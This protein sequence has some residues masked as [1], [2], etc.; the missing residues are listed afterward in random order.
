VVNPFFTP[1]VVVTQI[2]VQFT[3]M[4]GITM[5]QVTFPAPLPIQ[6]FGSTLGTPRGDMRF[7]LTLNVGCSI[8]HNGNMAVTVETRDGHGRRNS[9]RVDIN[10]R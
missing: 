6:E 9:K 8:G 10:V 1:G 3:D 5:P 2:Q 7:P 4:T